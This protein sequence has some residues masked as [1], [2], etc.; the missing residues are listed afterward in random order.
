MKNDFTCIIID[1]EQDAIDLLTQRLKL[2]ANEIEIKG[3]YLSWDSSLNAL[4]TQAFDI[5]FLD[6]SIHGKSGINLLKALPQIDSEIIFITAHERYMQS[7]FEFSTAGYLLKPI[8]DSELLRAINWATKRAMNKQIAARNKISVPASEHKIG[9][10][11]NKGI[12]YV[13]V[14]DILYLESINKCTKVVTAKHEYISSNNLGKFKELIDKLPFFQ[15]HRSFIVNIHSIMRYESDGF[16]IMADKKEIPV[17]RNI[18]H[19]FL[20]LFEDV[21]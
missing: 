20:Q 14:K 16:I 18:R 8:D 21:F 17:S 5:I 4:K 6:I 9:I 15:V 12:D 11:N 19:D 10:P 13:S 1:D 3:T 7:A 2:L